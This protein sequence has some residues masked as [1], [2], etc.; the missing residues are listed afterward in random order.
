MTSAL[1]DILVFRY[2]ARQLERRIS[3]MVK[4]LCVV[5]AMAIL[6]A[7]AS[8]S[9]ETRAGAPGQAEALPPGVVE[10]PLSDIKW[11][12]AANGLD[13]ANLVGDPDKP[14]PYLQLVRWPPNKRLPAHNHPDERHGMVILGVHYVGSGTRFD[15]K[16]LRKHTAGTYFT[17]PA[18]S[19]H[20]GETRSEGA[21]L[22]F[23][24][25]G[26]SGSTPLE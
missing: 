8:W 9:E 5:A 7:M 22:L 4:R 23:Y 13:H 6:P 21:I 14:G 20:F 17:E 10:I 2:K 16:K 11:I 19:P 26:P 25:T 18:S 12:R 15:E 3:V 1:N 24:G